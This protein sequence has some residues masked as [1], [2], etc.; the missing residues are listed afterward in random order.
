MFFVSRRACLFSA[1]LSLV[2]FPFSTAV[3]MNLTALPRPSPPWPG[4]PDGK[5]GDEPR[6]WIVDHSDAGVTGS[7]LL[8]PLRVIRADR[9]SAAMPSLMN[10]TAPSPRVT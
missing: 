6:R 3:N 8:P 2:G 5:D 7:S 4:E 10:L 9:T 1:A